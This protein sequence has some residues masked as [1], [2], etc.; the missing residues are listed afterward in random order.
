[1]PPIEVAGFGIVDVGNPFEIPRFG[2][3]AI[4]SAGNHL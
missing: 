3:A 4:P 2:H 1:M